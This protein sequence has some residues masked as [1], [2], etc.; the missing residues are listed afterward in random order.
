MYILVKPDQ[1]TVYPYSFYQLRRDNPRTSFRTDMT[2]SELAQW[3]MFPVIE[4]P[5]SVFD[6]EQYKEVV[7]SWPELVNGDWV[8]NKTVVPLTEDE[9]ASIQLEKQN[10]I[11]AHNREIL[12]STDWYVIRK[13]ETGIEVPIDITIIRETARALIV[14]IK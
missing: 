12:A 8:I 2:D 7:S 11:N 4:A 14:E 1:T 6:P 3:G 10:I 13:S 9:L 5:D